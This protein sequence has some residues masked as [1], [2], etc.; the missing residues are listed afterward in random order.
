MLASELVGE[1]TRRGGVARTRTLRPTGASKRDLAAAVATGAV[2]RLRT[3]V[4]ALPTID[5]VVQEALRHG[6]LVACATACVT[7]G[8]WV[9]DPWD[10]LVHVWVHPRRHTTRLAIQPEQDDVGC[11]VIHRDDAPTSA[12]AH[13]VGIVHALVQLLSCRGEEA[14]FA[15]L[16]SALRQGKLNAEARARIRRSVA[17]R[18]RWLVDFARS[19]ADSGLE[20]LL[21]LRLHR[22]GLQ[23]TSQVRVP[24][25]GDVDFVLG[26]CLIMEADGK[27]H[28]GESRHR[29][30]MRDAVALALGFVTLRFDYAMIV[31]DWLV[32]ENAVLAAV[33]RGLHRSPLGL[34]IEIESRS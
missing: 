9:L 20:S 3:G 19:D 30:R 1:L 4:Y 10:D 21:R 24:G 17:R 15:A 29:D 28:D 26:D 33:A 31:H 18:H 13:I 16:E 7:Y 8:L 11:C 32:V 22:R 12:G 14:F 6:G 5:P 23:L 25:V 34:R 27:T 2:L